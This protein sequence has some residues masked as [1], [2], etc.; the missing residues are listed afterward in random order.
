[1]NYKIKELTHTAVI[2]ALY[3]FLTYS[4]YPISYGIIQLRLSEVMTLLAY[5]SPKYRKG[6]ILGCAIANW[7]SPLGILDVIVGT[8]AT[9][10]SVYGISKTKNL[11]L[12]TLW[13]TINAVFIAFELYFLSKESFWY[14]FFSIAVS[15]LIVVTG[16]GYPFFKFLL[17]KEKFIS[18]LKKY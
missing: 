16:I 6:L 13:P 9:A 2:A 7:G 11:F 8:I 12:A 1:M 3:A 17:T 10:I 14:G 18:F 4:I 5:I 15:E